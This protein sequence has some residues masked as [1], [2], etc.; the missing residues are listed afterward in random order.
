M[1]ILGYTSAFLLATCG[2]F[3]LVKTLET[4]SVEGLSFLFLLT[5]FLGEL[6]GCVYVV[7]R[8]DYPLIWNYVLNLLVSLILLVYY[9]NS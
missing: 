9:M 4:G 7:K 1:K 2:I 3:Q 6:L 8:R 5:W